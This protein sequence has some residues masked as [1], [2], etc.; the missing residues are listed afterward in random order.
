MLQQFK[1]T[2]V[3]DSVTGNTIKPAQLCCFNGLRGL[4]TDVEV[5]RVP[6]DALHEPDD[7]DREEGPQELLPLHQGEHQG[8]G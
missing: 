6:A 5:P 1:N 4:C 7:G 2:E 3:N 8:W